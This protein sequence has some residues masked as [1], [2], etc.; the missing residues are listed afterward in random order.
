LKEF[1]PGH[2]G[3]DV[4]GKKHIDQ[5]RFNHVVHVMP[6][7]YFSAAQF[8]GRLKNHLPPDPGAV[9]TTAFRKVLGAADILADLCLNHPE[10]VPLFT[11]VISKTLYLAAAA[12]QIHVDREERVLQGSAGRMLVEEVEKAQA[13]LAAR[14]GHDNPV[15]GIDHII[16]DQGFPQLSLDTLPEIHVSP[17]RWV[18][19]SST[20]GCLPASENLSPM[21]QRRNPGSRTFELQWLHPG[22]ILIGNFGPGRSSLKLSNDR[23]SMGKAFDY[24]F[25]EDRI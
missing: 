10:D 4:P 25:T 14:N 2:H 6:Q 22:I 13:V 17:Q 18:Q 3:T 19:G 12:S 15:P 8:P 24:L 11:K 7:G 9:K 20:T 1:L 16:T 23:F 21:N 5:A